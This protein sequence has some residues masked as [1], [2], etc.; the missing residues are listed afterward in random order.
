MTDS[1][2]TINVSQADFSARVLESSFQVPV[3]VDFW[4]AWC[5]PCQ[6]LMPL[7]GRL[8]ES[9]Q[10]AFLL[11]KVNTDQEQALAHEYGVRALPTVKVF[12][13]GQVVEELVGVQPESAYRQVIERYQAKPSD[14]VKER[15]EQA[16]LQGEQVK[17][18][19]FLRDALDQDP[20]NADLKIS[21]AEKLLSGGEI[22]EAGELIGE[23][24]ATIRMDEPASRLLAQLEF[25]ALAENAPPLADLTDAVRNHPEDCA[26]R[27]QLGARLLLMDD[28]E[29][30]LDQFLE[31]L[32]RDPQF[33]DNAGR[34]GLLGI[35]NILGNDHP[36]TTSYRRKMASLLH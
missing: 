20:D 33:N 8:A 12:R 19:Q 2:Y 35:F 36:L 5:Q 16:W 27:Q 29:G 1:P 28:Y 4:A 26:K 11:A 15:A 23:L 30:A 13:N 9:A 32:R 14:N 7:L 21:L 18:L 34:K 6:I 22:Q 24:P 10:G 25:H 17:A 3:L 31:I